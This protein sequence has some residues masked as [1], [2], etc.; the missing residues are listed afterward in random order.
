MNSEVTIQIL[1][2]WG[3]SYYMLHIGGHV[4]GPLHSGLENLVG[5]VEGVAFVWLQKSGTNVITIVRC[6][7]CFV[8]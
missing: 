7:F 8:A 4:S 6:D 5:F 2:I 1:P 3:D